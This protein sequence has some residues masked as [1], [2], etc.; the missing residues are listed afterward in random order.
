[1]WK[2]PRGKPCRMSCREEEMPGMNQIDQA[3]ELQ[4]QG[5][6]PK[7]I[8][9]RLGID[10]KTA[11]RYAKRLL[12]SFD[13]G[14]KNKR[15]PSWTLGNRRSN[16]SW[17]MI[18][19]CVSNNEMLSNASTIGFSRN[20]LANMTAF[21]A[22]SISMPSR[23]CCRTQRCSASAPSTSWRCSSPAVWTPVVPVGDEQKQHVEFVRDIARRFNA[24]FG[25]L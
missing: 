18:R 5:Y 8:A 12:Q 20:T 19:G 9:E 14:A 25:D 13:G 16:G 23:R 1:M 21:S 2:F 3:K 10:R 7:E 11:V 15:L 17:E 24:T 4:R 6:G 22:W